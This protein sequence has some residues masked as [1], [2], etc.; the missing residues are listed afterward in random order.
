MITLIQK[1]QKSNSKSS[2]PSRE[3]ANSSAIRFAHRSDTLSATRFEMKRGGKVTE[4]REDLV[5]AIVL[6]YSWGHRSADGSYKNQD[7]VLEL[8]QR[9]TARGFKVWVDVDH[10][11]DFDPADWAEEV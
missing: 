4:E 11:D 7:K 2:A 10:I 5:D 3:A 8:K 6:L 9:L 1:G